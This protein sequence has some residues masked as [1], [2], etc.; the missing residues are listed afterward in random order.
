VRVRLARKTGCRRLYDADRGKNVSAHVGY[1]RLLL[2]TMAM[3]FNLNDSGD[4]QH[5]AV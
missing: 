3:S 4:K 1:L 5:F 2:G